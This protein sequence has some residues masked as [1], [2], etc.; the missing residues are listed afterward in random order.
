MTE[1]LIVIVSKAGCMVNGEDTSLTQ[2]PLS[3]MYTDLLQIQ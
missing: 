1:T 3:V 2:L